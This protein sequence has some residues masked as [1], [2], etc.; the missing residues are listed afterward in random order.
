M[1][2]PGMQQT[3]EPTTDKQTLPSQP[4]QTAKHHRVPVAAASSLPVSSPPLLPLQTL[5]AQHSPAEGS[6]Q[7]QPRQ[8]MLPAVTAQTQLRLQ[9]Q[10]LLR[11]P[12]SQQPEI[13]AL[14]EKGQP[15]L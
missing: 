14:L 12:L 15:H 3:P 2:P 1:Q 4:P 9:Q 7:P 6:I 13:S 11:S 8:V 5:T 10:G